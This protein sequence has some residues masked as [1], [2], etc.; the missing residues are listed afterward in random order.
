MRVRNKLR[1]L[2]AA[3]QQR[4]R[5]SSDRHVS[6]H[7]KQNYSSVKVPRDLLFEHRHYAKFQGSTLRNCR[8]SHLPD[9]DINGKM[10]KLTKLKRR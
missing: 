3:W 10:L 2:T 5:N 8:L 1:D 6:L 9:S 7:S 4:R